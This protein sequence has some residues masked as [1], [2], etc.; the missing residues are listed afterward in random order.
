[1]A[2]AMQLQAYI[3]RNML[4]VICNFEQENVSTRR[5][6]QASQCAIQWKI[7]KAVSLSFVLAL[8]VRDINIWNI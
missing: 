4:V 3:Y 5:I 7:S 1:M 6:K 2:G 8:T